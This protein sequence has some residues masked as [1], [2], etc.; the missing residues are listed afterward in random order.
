MS[1]STHTPCRLPYYKLCT[2]SVLNKPNSPHL[3]TELTV[4]E[5]KVKQNQ[6]QLASEQEA[7][8]D[9]S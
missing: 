7:Y 2:C 4:L 6:I 5:E 9:V 1:P 8:D 3:I